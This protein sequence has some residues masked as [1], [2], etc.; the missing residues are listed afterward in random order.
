MDGPTI[1]SI[2]FSGDTDKF[3]QIEFKTDKLSTK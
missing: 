1:L 2:T 3:Q